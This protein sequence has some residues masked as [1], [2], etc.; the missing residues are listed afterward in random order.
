VI[1]NAKAIITTINQ[2]ASEI[3]GYTKQEARGKNVKLLIPS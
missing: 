3:F 1:I 2:A